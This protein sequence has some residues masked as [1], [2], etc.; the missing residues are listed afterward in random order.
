[1]TQFLPKVYNDSHKRTGGNCDTSFSFVPIEHNKYGDLCGGCQEA[2]EYH[3]KH[4]TCETSETST[5]LDA[6]F[7]TGPSIITKT[8][9]ETKGSTTELPLFLEEDV[10]YLQVD[11]V[12]AFRY[13]SIENGYHWPPEGLIFCLR[14]RK[15]GWPSQS[16]NREAVDAGCH[17]VPK[18][19]QEHFRG[20]NPSHFKFFGT[21][22]LRPDTFRISF[23]A[24]EKVLAKSMTQPQKKCFLLL[25]VLLRQG[26]AIQNKQILQASGDKEKAQGLNEISGFLL[27]HV[28]FWAIEEIDLAEWRFNNLFCCMMK[29]LKKFESYLQEAII[30]H[31]FFGKQKN[32]LKDISDKEYFKFTIEKYLHIVRELMCPHNIVRYIY[33]N[34]FDTEGCFLDYIWNISSMELQESSLIETYTELLRAIS[35]DE[36]TV[37]LN[38]TIT[39]WNE[40]LLKHHKSM[41]HVIQNSPRRYGAG[42]NSEYLDF[43]QNEVEL[44]EVNRHWKLDKEEKKCKNVSE[45]PPDLT[46]D[47]V[48]AQAFN[49]MLAKLMDENPGLLDFRPKNRLQRYNCY[50]NLST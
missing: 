19:H 18:G 13:P 35:Y 27:K 17:V 23:S 25:K 41:I 24:A 11:N 50:G 34:L 48:R 14:Q 12:V 5:Y 6:V 39:E 1:M 32:I 42:V 21:R 38:I 7:P 31:Y 49:N 47:E 28:M 37:S 29:V 4:Q 36:Q 10:S 15:S 3:I 20:H 22:R 33:G 26:V 8:Y 40:K 45:D 16:L 2:N 44:L 30:P 46:Q 9:M 43:L